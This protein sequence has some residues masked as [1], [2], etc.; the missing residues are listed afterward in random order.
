MPLT[1]QDNLTISIY[2]STAKH[3]NAKQNPTQISVEASITDAF[4]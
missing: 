2:M 1:L 3:S 4:H